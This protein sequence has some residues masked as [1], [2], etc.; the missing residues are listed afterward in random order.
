M[1]DAS[2]NLDNADRFT[3]VLELEV[4]SAWAN[5]DTRPG[6]TGRERREKYRN[7][8]A[9]GKIT[10]PV[11]DPLWWAFRINVEKANRL[12]DVDNVAKTV[13][14]AFC[15]KQIEAN[16]GRPFPV[17]SVAVWRR[18][19]RRGRTGASRS[20]GAT[21]GIDGPWSSRCARGSR[22]SPQRRKRSARNGTRVFDPI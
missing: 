15:I 19:W 6:K 12:I 7:A 3:E 14:D 1:T 18:W 16:R 20:A 5:A 10:K 13:I 9:Q 4:D 22:N 21:G 2:V 8:A 17:F 11:S